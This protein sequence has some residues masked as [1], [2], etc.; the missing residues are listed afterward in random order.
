[1]W[2]SK[3]GLYNWSMLKEY[4]SMSK[5]WAPITDER[6]YLCSL[7][8][9]FTSALLQHPDFADLS[10]YYPSLK[11]PLTVRT[12]DLDAF[13]SS[14]IEMPCTWKSYSKS[15]LPH[16]LL[17]KYKRRSSFENWTLGS[18]VDWYIGI[19][20]KQKSRTWNHFI[21]QMRTEQF[22]PTSLSKYIDF[23]ACPRDS[24][25]PILLVEISEPRTKIETTHKDMKNLSISMVFALMN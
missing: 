14:F 2:A 1:M 3:Y 13:E 12:E 6:S 21:E 20:F 7:Y 5:T 16:I 4:A 11:L 9:V 19:C 15:I 17:S 25:I 24:G 8:N 18:V 22:D 10:S 23:T